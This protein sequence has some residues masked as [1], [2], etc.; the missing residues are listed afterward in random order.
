[1]DNEKS[2]SGLPTGK[3]GTNLADDVA[4][5][6]ATVVA[7]QLGEKLGQRLA[8]TLGTRVLS[9]GSLVQLAGQLL[10]VVTLLQAGGTKIAE[11]VK[12][13]DFV[14]GLKKNAAQPDPGVT[15]PS[16]EALSE[17]EVEALVDDLAAGI[18]PFIADGN[19][20]IAINDKWRK[21][22]PVGKTKKQIVD[23]L[24]E[25]V[26]SMVRNERTLDRVWKR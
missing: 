10:I 12:N 4:E 11:V 15:P 20:L 8:F 18:E 16:E 17:M 19:V 1:M 7:K 25:D 9:L 26:K 6:L 22:D 21:R 3:V 23:L 2:L 24:F 14:N 13:V 5:K